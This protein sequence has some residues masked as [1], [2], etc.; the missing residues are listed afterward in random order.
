MRA[1]SGGLRREPSRSATAASSPSQWMPSGA[2]ATSRRTGKCA[3]S[4]EKALDRNKTMGTG[5]RSSMQAKGSRRNRGSPQDPL[6]ADRRH[7]GLRRREN[8]DRWAEAPPDRLLRLSAARRPREQDRR[9]AKREYAIISLNDQIDG[10]LRSWTWTSA[11]ATISIVTRWF[12]RSSPTSARPSRSE[13]EA[14]PLRS[15]QAGSA[16]S[17]RSAGDEKA[18]ALWSKPPGCPT[19]GLGRPPRARPTRF[20]T[21]GVPSRQGRRPDPRGRSSR[22]GRLA[23]SRNAS[24]ASFAQARTRDDPGSGRE[25]RQPFRRRCGNAGTTR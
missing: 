23:P 1:A 7:A 24:S 19:P 17:S 22:Q 6:P 5:S 21:S 18:I 14:D 25:Q 12:S 16:R 20:C 11:E 2:G 4:Y 15:H 10:A 8:L 3:D 9:P 13:V